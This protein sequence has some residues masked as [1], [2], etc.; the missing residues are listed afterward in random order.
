MDSEIGGDLL[1]RHPGITVASYPDDI[2]TELTGIGLGHSDILP[3]RPKASQI[4]CHLSMQQSPDDPEPP[5]TA[6]ALTR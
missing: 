1:Q 4:W 2:V 3:A 5:V 6:S